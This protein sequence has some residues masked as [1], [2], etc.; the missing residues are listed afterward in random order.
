MLGTG[1]TDNH[2][3]RPSERATPATVRGCSEALKSLDRER[4]FCSALDGTARTCRG[5]RR[6][7]RRRGALRTGWLR[8]V[9]VR[10]AAGSARSSSRAPPTRL[11][12]EL[13]AQVGV[14]ATAAAQPPEQRPA[15]VRADGRP[16]SY[17]GTVPS[18]TQPS[19]TRPVHAQLADR[20]GALRRRETDRLAR[21]AAACARRRR[22]QVPRSERPDGLGAHAA[23]PSGG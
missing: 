16:S 15:T 17:A 21:R 22:R 5:S 8:P 14:S 11:A 10:C 6:R 23:E 9:L 1:R 19:C 7:R 13:V 2:R 20:R 18:R 3:Q 4:D 12:V